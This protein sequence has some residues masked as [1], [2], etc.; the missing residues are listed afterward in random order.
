[1]TSTFSACQI[2]IIVSVDTKMASS[3]VLTQPS[4]L[5]LAR[6]DLAL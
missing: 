6:L 5:A 1:M 3:P 4:Q 2:N